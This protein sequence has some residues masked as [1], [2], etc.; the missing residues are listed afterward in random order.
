MLVILSDIAASPNQSPVQPIVHY[1]VTIIGGTRQSFNSLWY[2]KYH[3]LEYSREKDAVYCFPCRLFGS[4]NGLGRGINTF[5]QQGFCDW[6]HA[7]GKSGTLAKHN[8]SFA[9]KQAVSAWIDYKT[10]WTLI[11]DRVDSQTKQQ[12]Q[13]NRHYLKTLAEILLL[14]GKQDIPLRRHREHDPL[15]NRGNFLEILKTVSMHDQIIKEKIET[16]PR[17]A[18]YTSPGI[19]NSFLKILGDLIRKS[20]CDGVKEAKMFSLL[21]D[22]TKY[23]SKTEQVS[24]VVR[25]VD[26]KG[27]I[28]EHFL[29]F[30][31]TAILTAEGLT[32][33]IFDFLRN[34][35]WIHSGL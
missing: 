31:D 14:C 21:V 19:Q 6:K 4:C 26:I 25:F 9:H 16:G 5:I 17:N 11:E 10:N 13:G 22:E 29:T 3:W 8:N 1:Q 18:I 27:T 7:T 24:T 35:S 34:F 30:I 12:I 23:I 2:K 33:H 28:C 20:V 15:L 32:K